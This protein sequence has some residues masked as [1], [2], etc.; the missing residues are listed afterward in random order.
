F[1][2]P[3]ASPFGAPAP[4]PPVALPLPPPAPVEEPLNGTN[5]VYDLPRPA[6][7]APGA[8]ERLE[9]LA[10][11]GIEAAQAGRIAVAREALLAYV[12]LVGEVLA[13]R[14]RVVTLFPSHDTTLLLATDI[15]NGYYVLLKPDTDRGARGSQAGRPAFVY[16]GTGFAI[17]N[18]GLGGISLR[19]FLG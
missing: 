16:Q 12:E 9:D 4:P 5:S 2:A 19:H 8:E 10:R 13:R 14:Y 18:I 6:A 11:R 1:G 3:A 15:R 17:S 7:P